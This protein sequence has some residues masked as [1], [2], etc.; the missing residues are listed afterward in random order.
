MKQQLRKII[1]K[2]D[3]LEKKKLEIEEELEIL[4]LQKMEVENEEIVSV[5]RN[6]IISL[7]ELLDYAKRKEEKK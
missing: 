2:I 5:C 1:T 7:E 6:N 3:K 4:Y